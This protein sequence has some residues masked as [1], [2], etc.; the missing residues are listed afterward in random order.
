MKTVMKLTTMLSVVLG[1]GAVAN[2]AMAGVCYSVS[3]KDVAQGAFQAEVCDG[4]IAGVAGYQ[5]ERIKIRGTE[6]NANMCYRVDAGGSG[7][8]WKTKVC[9]NTAAGTTGT[10][11][12]AIEIVD[13][14]ISADESVYYQVL[15]E[16]YGWLPLRWDGGVGGTTGESKRMEG[17]AIAV[18]PRSPCPDADWLYLNGYSFAL[19]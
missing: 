16:S 11:I 18:Q 10:R 4:I 12:E 1:I 14:A 15:S 6:A 5:I 8:G 2:S 19:P 7:G 13:T 9:N 3:Q 17:I